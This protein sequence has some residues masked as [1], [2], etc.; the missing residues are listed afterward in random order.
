MV[1]RNS[2]TI[3]ASWYRVVFFTAR[4]PI[5]TAAVLSSAQ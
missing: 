5:R 1:E 2:R 4:F 3:S